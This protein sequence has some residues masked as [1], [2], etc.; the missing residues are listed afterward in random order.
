MKLNVCSTCSRL[1][2]QLSIDAAAAFDCRQRGQFHDF[3]NDDYVLLRKGTVRF[4]LSITFMRSP[5][6]EVRTRHL[7]HLTRAHSVSSARYKHLTFVVRYCNFS[8][9]LV[10]EIILPVHVEELSAND[11]CK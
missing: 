7:K 10:E 2:L 5:S 3:H 8:R 1:S 9:S 6:R 4:S 11:P